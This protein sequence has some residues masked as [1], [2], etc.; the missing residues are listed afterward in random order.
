[1]SQERS[2]PSRGSVSLVL[3]GGGLAFFAAS[4]IWNGSNFLFHVIMSR[5]LGPVTYGAL[6]SLLGIITVITFAAGAIQAAVVQG[7]AERTGE[8]TRGPLALRRQI[9]RAGIAAAASM[10]VLTTLSPVI[11]R[12][13]HLASPYPVFL[14]GLFVALSLLV[15]VP[16]GVLLGRLRF[17]VVAVSLVVA[18]FCRLGTGI[19]LAVLGF[20]LD[21][22]LAASVAAACVMLAVLL[23]PLRHELLCGTGDVLNINLSSAALAVSDLGGFA[24]LVGIDS[25]LARHYLGGA[26]SGEYVAAA[27][28]ARIALF[29]PGAIALIAFPKFS[30]ARGVGEETRHVLVTS[31]LI[32]AGLGTLAAAATLL[33]PHLVIATLFGSKYQQAADALRILYLPGAGLGLVSLLVYFHLARRSR[34]TLLCWVGVALATISISIF[35]ASPVAIAWSMFFVTGLMV[36]V[37]G[38]GALLDLSDRV[39]V[40]DD[41]SSLLQTEIADL[42]LSIVVPYFNPGKRVR[43]T[44]DQIVSVLGELSINYE[45]ITVSDGSTDGS[46]ETLTGLPSEHVHHLRLPSN[47]GKGQALRVGLGMGRGEYLGFIDADGDL[48]PTLLRS[49]VSLIAREKPDIVLGSKRHPDSQVIYPPLRRFYSWLYQHVVQV[50]FRLTVR[51]TQTGVKFIRRDVLAQVLPRML[52]KRFAFDLELLV[53]AQQLGFGHLAELPVTIGTR[54]SSTV[55]PRAVVKSAIDTC[56]IFYRLH[57]L[58]YYGHR[59]HRPVVHL[60]APVAPPVLLTTSDSVV[61]ESGAEPEESTTTS[62][63]NLRILVFNWRDITHPSAGGAEVYAHEVCSEWVRAGHEVTFFTSQHGRRPRS[64]LLDGIH[65]VRRGGRYTVYREARRFYRHDARR[66]FDLVVDVVNTRPFSCPRF[67]KDVPVLAIIFQ[68]TREIWLR[69]S[70]LPFAL[71][72]RY[73][74]EPRWIRAYRDVPVVTISPSSRDSLEEYGLQRMTVVPVG[75]RQSDRASG[76]IDREEVPTVLFVGRLTENKRPDDALEAFRLLREQVP[77]AQ[78]WVIGTGPKERQLRARQIAGVSFLGRVSED[79]KRERLA[80]AH[81]VVA[82]SVR[83]G[84]GLIVSEAA[85]FGTPT[86][87]YNVP[88]LCDSVIASGGLLVRP[89]SRELALELAKRLPRWAAGDL[90]RVAPNGVAAWSDVAM[91]ILRL[92]R[93]EVHDHRSSGSS[94]QECRGGTPHQAVS[95]SSTIA[96][97]TLASE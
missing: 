24:S 60:G 94:L 73:V 61:S 22:A 88:G 52:E 90:P 6:G 91:Q 80:R 10:F 66:H 3:G 82:T 67:V 58:H 63:P 97:G 83:E 51:D 50:L 35:H 14:L 20:G 92:V 4:C 53:V 16:Q 49:F 71:V 17:R 89:S 57:L 76:P 21:G 93:P 28:A 55:S 43:T 13:L 11:E 38:V 48:P 37:L 86:I 30:A 69:E 18:A 29:L 40:A 44:V 84:W 36:A 25:F 33:L 96:G 27:T 64:E 31:L 68:V 75:M 85:S 70:W 62:S 65:I 56:A 59:R 95:A 2:A 46:E 23:W 34:Q 81:V 39:E 87:A 12:Y 74:L 5:I 15:L 9:S 32:V 26:A 41:R 19:V 42:D 8:E 72:G 7:V 77:S 1:M 79:V 45:I 78:M 47:Q 54:F